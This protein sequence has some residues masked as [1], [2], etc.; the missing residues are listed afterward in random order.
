MPEHKDTEHKYQIRGH[1]KS[2]YSYQ[3]RIKPL[4]WIVEDEEEDHLARSVDGPHQTILREAESSKRDW[5][6]KFRVKLGVLDD[7]IHIESLFPIEPINKHLCSST[8]D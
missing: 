7:K 3:G 2:L 8:E 1:S 5:I 4:P 6:D